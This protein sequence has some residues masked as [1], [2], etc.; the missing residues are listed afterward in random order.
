MLNKGQVG[1]SAL[2]RLNYVDFIRFFSIIMVITLHCIC[3]YYVDSVNFNKKLWFLI[4]FVNELC[5]TGVPLFFM[6][7]GYLILRA[8]IPD[9]GSFYRRRILKIGIPF[10]IYNAFYYTFFCLKNGVSISVAGLFKEFINCG[11][12]YHLW[13]I[14]S[15]FFLYLIMPFVKIIVDNVGLK[16][17]TVFF[18]FMI[19]QTTVKPFL[20]TIFG[21]G[22]YFYFAEDGM[23][24]YLGYMILGYI[25]GNFDLS[26][27]VRRFIY[28]LGCVFFVATPLASMRSAASG[29]EF[30][31]IGGYSAN[32]YAEA[33]AIFLLCK[34]KFSFKCSFLTLLSKLTFG[35]YFAH[36][37][38]LE[39][40]KTVPIDTLP[41]VKISI[42]VIFTVIL[43]F[44]WGFIEFKIIKLVKPKTAVARS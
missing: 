27:R 37:F 29:K 28:I 15:I 33:A 2:N 26:T 21:G 32:H 40:L 23:V 31:F 11:S 4:G 36:V 13:F 38:I 39:L 43:S 34:N 25:L 9:F 30:L 5:R 35:A 10:L 12:A 20:N 1:D 8:D 41:S 17:L 22:L 6:I 18:F 14:Y 7:S 24:G 42:W 19:F 16:M 44:F 3:D